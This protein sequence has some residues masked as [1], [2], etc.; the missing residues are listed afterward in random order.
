MNY[1]AFFDT[2][3]SITLYDPLSELLGAFEEGK[4][5]V[6]YLDV[7]KS[8]GHSC[9]TIAGAYLMVREGLKKLYP[10]TLPV[11]GEIE[12][13]FKEGIEEGTTGVVANVFSFITGATDVWGFKGLSG[14]FSRTQRMHFKA[15]ISLHVKMKRLDTGVEVNVAYDPNSIPF[16]PRV[17]ALMPKLFTSL[18]TPEEKALFATLWQERVAKILEN[19]DKVILL[20]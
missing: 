16:D 7:V 4:V 11:R 18:L 6:S 1:P 14:H 20:Q 8:A 5:C 12:V 9:P 13:F 17:S 19:F 3:S 10:D 2:V 15:P